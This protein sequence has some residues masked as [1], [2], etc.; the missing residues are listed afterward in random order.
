MT[1]RKKYQKDGFTLDFDS[2]VSDW[3]GERDFN[4][5]MLEVELTVEKESEILAASE[6]IGKFAQS[7]GFKIEKTDGKVIEYLLQKRS[8]H[9]AALVE[10]GIVKTKEQDSRNRL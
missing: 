7:N 3:Q 8:K 10:A 9:Y 4:Y 6:Q 5:Q 1:T 2:A